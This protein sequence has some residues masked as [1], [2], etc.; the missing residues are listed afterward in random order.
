V[1][2]LL[3]AF[4]TILGGAVAFALGQLILEGTVKPALELKRLIGAVAF[5]LDFYG[6]ND[7]YKGEKLEQEWRSRLARH[8]IA[9]REKLNLILWYSGFKVFCGFLPQSTCWKPHEI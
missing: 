7:L 1:K 2:I 8:A 9:L 4:A 5:D 3:T 6:T